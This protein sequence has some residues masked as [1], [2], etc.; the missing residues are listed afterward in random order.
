M[1]LKVFGAALLG[2]LLMAAMP[3]RADDYPS[4][5]I[6]VIVPFPPGGSSD[7]VM[8][9]VASKVAE[10][11]KQPIIIENRSGAAGNVAAMAIKNAAPDGYLL[12]MGHTGTHAMNS[13][14]YK[15]LKFD[16]VKDFQPITAL[17]SFNNI[18]VVPAASP[19]KSVGELVA[20]AKTRPEG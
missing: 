3:A 11:I 8:R 9:L 19:A 20:Y 4:R 10:S 13:A 1:R 7:I 6:T 15:D 12:M 18:L 14:L 16:P 17:I 5:P 2:A